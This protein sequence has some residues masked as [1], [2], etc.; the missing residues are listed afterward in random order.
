MESKSIIGESMSRAE[1]MIVSNPSIPAESPN[2]SPDKSITTVP[3][4]RRRDSFNLSKS[5]L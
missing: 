5:E 1:D 2:K 3:Q 4:F